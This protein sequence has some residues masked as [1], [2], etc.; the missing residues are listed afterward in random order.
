MGYL[1]HKEHF[2]IAYKT[3]TDVWT[4]PYTTKESLVLTGKLPRGAYILDIGSGRGFLSKHLADM[5]FKVIG[6][7]FEGEIVKKTNEDI[8]DWGLEGKLKF[9]E[10]DILSIPFPDESFDG[11]CDFGLFETLNKEDWPTYVKEVHRVLKPGGFY[12]NVSLSRETQNFFEFSPKKEEAVDFE[13]YG[14][15]YHFFG[16]DEMR[17]IFANKFTLVSEQTA[18]AKKNERIVLL[19]TLFQKK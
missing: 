14:I 3:G 9:V 16:K 19:E 7:D 10:A 18:L 17:D 2:N 13:K 4:H 6:I 1:E 11:A 12:L 15:H 8:K 5:G